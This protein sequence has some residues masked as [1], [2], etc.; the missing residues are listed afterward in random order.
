MMFAQNADDSTRRQRIMVD[1]ADV[2]SITVRGDEEGHPEVTNAVRYLL[3]RHQLT[4]PL[5]L[6]RTIAVVS[7]I[8]GE[9][10]T[11]VATAL[12]NLLAAVNG[13][14]ACRISMATEAPGS[15]TP[16]GPENALAI[17]PGPDGAPSPNGGAIVPSGR[18][19]AT[20]ATATV[21][22]PDLDDLLQRLVTEYDY[23]V[24]DTPPLLSQTSSLGLLRH[25]DVYLLVAR[26]GA[27]TIGQV[28]M[29]AEELRTIPSVGTVLNRFRTRTPRFVRRRFSE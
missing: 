13:T 24:L 5:P 11:T 18:A 27:T 10:V 23:L 15:L 9:G 4:S 8:G 7:A 12:S 14:E 28:Q 20:P 16:P 29:V 21:G 25:A 1:V 26:Y 2:T 19:G 3:D 22:R 17:S 6:P